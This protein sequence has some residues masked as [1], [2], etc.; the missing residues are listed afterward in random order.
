MTASALIMAPAMMAMLEIRRPSDDWLAYLGGQQ[1]LGWWII[2]SGD[3]AIIAHAGDTMGFSG[4]IALNLKTR[5]GVVVLVNGA[6]G[7][8]DLAMHLLRPSYPLARPTTPIIRQE[9][10]VDPRLFGLYAGK[11]QCTPNV[12]LVIGRE[13]AKLTF[14]APGSPRVSLHAQSERE[15]FIADTDVAVTFQVNDQGQTTG[16][17][18]HLYGQF[19]VP[20]KRIEG[21]PKKT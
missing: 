19:D 15:Y 14:M 12:I 17:I 7:G 11:Y 10:A 13:G 9:V 20:A 6:S 5:I 1:A 2:G 4:S 18:L 21:G 3:D 8:D 16:L